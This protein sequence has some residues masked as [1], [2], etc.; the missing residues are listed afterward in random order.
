MRSR[1]PPAGEGGLAPHLEVRR[2]QLGLEGGAQLLGEGTSSQVRP[3][4]AMCWFRRVMRCA[5]LR[6]PQVTSIVPIYDGDGAPPAAAPAMGKARAKGGSL[7]ERTITAIAFLHNNGVLALPTDLK[8]RHGERG[9]TRATCD[10]GQSAVP[11][12]LRL[13]ADAL[14]CRWTR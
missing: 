13:A 10:G 5:G 2:S 3:A 12:L 7:K 9:I 1:P 14:P 8:V 11:L 4:V 6:P